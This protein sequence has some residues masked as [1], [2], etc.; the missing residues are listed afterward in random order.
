MAGRLA[1]RLRAK[2]LC[3]NHV[4]SS[5][6]DQA[7]TVDLV[8]VV[9]ETNENQS[10]VV[11][12]RDFLQLHIP[13]GGYEFPKPTS[14]PSTATLFGQTPLSPSEDHNAHQSNVASPNNTPPLL[15][16]PSSDEEPVR[17]VPS[18]ST[19]QPTSSSEARSTLSQLKYLMTR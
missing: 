1:R 12:G 2:V 5:L 11:V 17:I 8:N 6:D 18:T 13:K 3:I 19:S 15:P 4:S 10:Q 16:L 7:E 14:R 9:K